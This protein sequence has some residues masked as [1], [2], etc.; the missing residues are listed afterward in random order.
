MNTKISCYIA[1]LILLFHATAFATLRYQECLQESAQQ[2]QETNMTIFANAAHTQ[3]LLEMILLCHKITQ[4]ACDM[5]LAKHTIQEELLKIYTPSLIDSWQTNLQV[6]N[7][8]T[9]KLEQ[10]LNTIKQSQVNLL[11]FFDQ[12]K[13][14]TP[15]F[16]HIKP[17]PTQTMITNLKQGL[18]IWTMQQNDIA[19]YIDEIQTEFTSAVAN[20]DDIKTLFSITL[21][22]SDH[23]CNK[24][25][26]KQAAGCVSKTYKDVET[27]LQH[28]TAI[29]KTSIYRIKDFFS[30]FFKIYYTQLYQT[31]TAQQQIDV[32]R[33][34][35]PAPH[36]IF[37]TY[38]IL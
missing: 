33:E 27:V 34:K 22:S 15:H 7:N 29:R 20:I 18:L 12:L 21:P 4:E 9:T 19:G 23:A 25:N 36:E 16:L 10:A 35:L 26:L 37:V 5:L 38:A 13:L 30:N 6:I 28:F 24:N 11:S 2:W 32:S 3:I 31:L 8:D 17:Q 1:T 14:I